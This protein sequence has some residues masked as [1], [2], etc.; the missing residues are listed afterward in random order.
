MEDK[1]E[2]EFVFEKEKLLV[3]SSFSHPLTEYFL[4][5]FGAPHLRRVI[6]LIILLIVENI[7]RTFSCVW[8]Q[9]FSCFH[10]GFF[11]HSNCQFYLVAL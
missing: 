9:S 6:F 11:A 5:H 10:S 2:F 1:V 3:Y 8:N 7:Q 4:K